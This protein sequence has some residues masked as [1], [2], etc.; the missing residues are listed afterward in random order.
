MPDPCPTATITAATLATTVY[1]LGDASLTTTIPLFTVSPSFCIDAYDIQVTNASPAALL[2]QVTT[3]NSARTFTVA[4]SIDASI[5]GTAKIKVSPKKD[6]VVIAGAEVEYDLQVIDPC[7]TATIT[8]T[9]L[10]TTVY[11]LS[12]PLLTTTIP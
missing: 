6:G 7:A 1:T 8:H 10:A 12:D 2:G 3:S 9:S 4:Y 11:T 5:V